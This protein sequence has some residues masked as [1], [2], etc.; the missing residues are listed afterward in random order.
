MNAR[1]LRRRLIAECLEDR[2]A[3]AGDA[4][5][6]MYSQPV[7]SPSYSPAM[8]A[9]GDFGYPMNR[10]SGPTQTPTFSYPTNPEPGWQYLS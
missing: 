10:P 2:L 5:S 7:A 6:Y 8:Y 1:S 4:Y 9:S 3:L